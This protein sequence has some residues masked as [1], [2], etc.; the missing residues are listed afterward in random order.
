MT[1]R[2]SFI[3]KKIILSFAEMEQW[4]EKHR[5]ICGNNYTFID[6][7]EVI[8]PNPIN[9]TYTIYCTYKQYN[10]LKKWGFIK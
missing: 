4:K 7:W 5:N 2:D 8:Q 9:L 10:N 3:R 1:Q 6:V